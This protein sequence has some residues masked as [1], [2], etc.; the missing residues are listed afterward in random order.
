[1]VDEFKRTVLAWGYGDSMANAL[2]GVATLFGAEE[3]TFFGVAKIAALIGFIATLLAYFSARAAADPLRIVKFYVVFIGVVWLFFGI[4]TTVQ[5]HDKALNKTYPVQNVPYPVAYVLSFIT[6]VEDAIA[7]QVDRAF[8]LAGHHCGSEKMGIFA[9]SQIMAQAMDMRV[10]DPYL[11]LNLTNF[12]QDCVFTNILD[13]SLDA[14]TLETS[15]NLSALIFN[16]AHLHPARFTVLYGKDQ[17]KYPC[18]APCGGGCS[19]TCVDA[20]MYLKS[21]LSQ[22]V[23]AHGLNALSAAVG[24]SVLWELLGTV[25]TQIMHLKQT[26]TGFLMQAVLMNQFKETY[27][28]WAASYG[29]GLTEQG[30]F[31]KGQIEKA[32]ANRYLP[33]IKGILHV[34]FAS[35][36]P[37]LVIFMLTPLM[38]GAL[39]FT[40]IFGLWMIVWKFTE[41]VVNG[42]FY[43]KLEGNFQNFSSQPG[44]DLNIANAPVISALLVDHISLAG[45]LYWLVPTVSF[46]V[47][48]LGGYAFHS[49]ATGLGGV[50]QSTAQASAGDVAKGSFNAGQVNY[51]N[52]S[53]GNTSFGSFVYGTTNAFT[54]AF[55]QES[56]RNITKEGRRV[57]VRGA[58]PNYVKSLVAML[59]DEY[60]KNVVA[61]VLGIVGDDPNTNIDISISPHGRVESIVASGGSSGFRVTYTGSGNL[62]VERR[63]ITHGNIKLN[64]KGVIE[65]PGKLVEVG[66]INTQAIDAA[67]KEI[68][69][70]VNVYREVAEAISDFHTIKDEAQRRDKFTKAFENLFRRDSRTFIDVINELGTSQVFED[71]LKKVISKQQSSEQSTTRGIKGKF[72]FKLGSVI[73]LLTLKNLNFVPLPDGSVAVYLKHERTTKKVTTLTSEEVSNMI[74]KFYEAFKERK[75][76]REG[77]TRANINKTGSEN[78]FE[79]SESFESGKTAE[80]SKKLLKKADEALRFANSK[81][82][83][84]IA[85]PLNDYYKQKFEEGLRLFNGD[86]AKAIRY[87]HE[88]TEKLINDDNAL[89][90]YI[91]EYAI[92]RGLK[93]LWEKEGELKE[94]SEQ[95]KQQTNGIPEEQKTIKE[96]AK[97]GQRDIEDTINRKG[98]G[99]NNGPSVQPPKGNNNGPS[100]QPPKNK[101]DKPIYFN[102]LPPEYKNLLEFLNKRNENNNGGKMNPPFIID[103][104]KKIPYVNNGGNNNGEKMNTSFDVR[105]GNNNGEKMNTSF[106]VRRGGPST[107]NNV[108]NSS[109]KNTSGASLSFE[110]F[111]FTRTK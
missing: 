69:E 38:K 28:S 70:M 101:K 30:I 31:T 14:H 48:S 39:M 110:N 45:S 53:A 77:T 36:V 76:T 35:L 86:K 16:P 40:F 67:R 26:G 21:A 82:V 111:P 78:S 58:Q 19:M 44:W 3:G 24:Q 52:V 79:K 62:K 92:N 54:G 1:M 106:D 73:D 93:D 55:L 108:R 25:P 94:V 13:G 91:K 104:R 20:G 68:E 74:N 29:M 97:Q 42:F 15:D 10:V 57:Q 49:F 72:G 56:N 96:Q 80:V 51:R 61:Q 6:Q 11:Y 5:V 34:L 105:R 27:R 65:E 95:V 12:F 81:E 98:K 71:I 109:L 107:V 66:L 100:V 23:N 7:R 64:E 8:G 43:S 88:E 102:Q 22:W 99:N 75:I 83:Q 50:V 89:K 46:V 4:T 84:I 2:Q 17:C 18:N 60:T 37:L 47:A 59:G 87:A 103:V 32:T 41:S 9:C 63:G 33:L 90:E 85:N